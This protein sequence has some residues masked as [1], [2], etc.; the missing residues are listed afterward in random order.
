MKISK[1]QFYM[2]TFGIISS[3]SIGLNFIESKKLAEK[4]KQINDLEVDL[5]LEK[6]KTD[7]ISKDLEELK[8]IDEIETLDEL[9]DYFDDKSYEFEMYIDHGYPSCSFYNRLNI[10]NYRSS[11]DNSFVLSDSLYRKINLILSQYDI[12][13]IRFIDLDDSFDLNRLDILHQNNNYNGNYIEELIF[14]DCKET[15]DY[16]ALL[17]L[18][19]KYISIWE[20]E[21]KDTSKVQSYLGK[22]NLNNKTLG[23]QSENIKDYL[24]YFKEKN[25]EIGSL[26]IVKQKLNQEELDLFKDVPIKQLALFTGTSCDIQL[27]D[28]TEYFNMVFYNWDGEL[29]YPDVIEKVKID[30]NHPNF[31]LMISSELGSL[32]HIRSVTYITDNTIFELPKN[33]T[34]TFSDIHYTTQER[35]DEGDYDFARPAEEIG[36]IL[37]GTVSYH[38][39]INANEIVD[40]IHKENEERERE[41]VKTKE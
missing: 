8:K 3:L 22:I 34:I 25:M 7:Y 21:S 28:S 6:L 12:N 1:T 18:N 17:T 31:R 15:F 40:A 30:S 23:F 5:T 16:D 35:I 10:R 36:P 27:H 20:S 26:N 39:E 9:N 4:T 2:A 11:Y 13:A 41:K 19:P 14:W 33:S 29:K 24:T 38:E 37:N 32:L